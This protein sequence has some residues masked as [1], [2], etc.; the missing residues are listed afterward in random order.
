MNGKRDEPARGDV[1]GPSAAQLRL[2]SIV[3][4]AMDAII[5]E[6]GIRWHRRPRRA[7]TPSTSPA[8]DGDREPI[9]CSSPPC[10]LHEF[11]R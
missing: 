2:E 4:S 1:E 9:E 8:D 3:Q 7:P 5:T 11:D 10:Y 6:E